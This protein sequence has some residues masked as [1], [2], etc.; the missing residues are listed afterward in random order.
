MKKALTSLAAVT[1]LSTISLNVTACGKDDYLEITNDEI[2]S[3]PGYPG[4]LIDLSLMFMFGLPKD[5][6]PWWNP[7]SFKS[8]G[9]NLENRKKIT[10]DTHA[11]NIDIPENKWEWWYL[12]I[13][14][15]K[16]KGIFISNYKKTN[17]PLE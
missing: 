3:T 12:T 7:D 14:K 6:K 5:E 2:F 15:T 11:G 4:K 9:W 17:K 13:Q 10:L 1:F 8:W 16:S